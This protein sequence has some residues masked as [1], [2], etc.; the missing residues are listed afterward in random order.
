MIIARLLIRW[1]SGIILRILI[2][3]SVVICIVVGWIVMH[4]VVMH[5]VVLHWVVWIVVHWIHWV[6]HRIEHR[7]AVVSL[8]WHA[9][10][11]VKLIVIV[12]TELISMILISV[13]AKVLA[14]MRIVCTI[15]VL[16][17][18][19]WIIVST[20]HW[21]DTSLMHG[22]VSSHITIEFWLVMLI[23]SIVFLPKLHLLLIRLGTER[24]FRFIRHWIYYWWNGREALFF[25]KRF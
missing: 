18:S 2:R 17:E 22:I 8:I 21:I 13:L 20:P 3:L 4:W 25:F 12:W 24:S 14:L 6:I 7:I 23:W 15:V 9:S 1:I 16:I 5:W 10:V 19:H 11:L